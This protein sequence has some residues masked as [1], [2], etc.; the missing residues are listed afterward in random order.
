MPSMKIGIVTGEIAAL[1]IGA[2]D[3]PERDDLIGSQAIA[4]LFCCLR[5]S[6]F[7]KRGLVLR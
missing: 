4:F 1:A 7:L 2:F 6:R 5:R 3:R